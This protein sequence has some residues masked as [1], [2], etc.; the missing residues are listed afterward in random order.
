[1]AVI[2]SVKKAVQ[3]AIHTERYASEYFKGMAKK[4]STKEGAAMYT[5]LAAEEMEHAKKLDAILKSL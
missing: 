1:V 3:L 5:E 4:A 2:D